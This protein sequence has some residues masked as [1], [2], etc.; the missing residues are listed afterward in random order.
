[1]SLN[2]TV[3]VPIDAVAAISQ[4][5]DA[6]KSADA[7]ATITKAIIESVK[8]LSYEVKALKNEDEREEDDLSIVSFDGNAP[9]GAPRPSKK[10]K[11][12]HSQLS[13][14]PP[15]QIVIKDAYG[16]HEMYNRIF[17]TDTIETMKF[18]IQDRTGVP[19][20]QQRLIWGG[21]QLADG[22]TF[23]QVGSPAVSEAGR[24]FRRLTPYFSTVSRTDRFCISSSA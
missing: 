22:R 13:T 11:R 23:G 7:I 15:I 14:S 4:G 9:A 21:A 5:C 20:D 24:R 16:K 19:P 8:A 1:M 10:T 3:A 6:L 17:T 2:L 18:L 12:R